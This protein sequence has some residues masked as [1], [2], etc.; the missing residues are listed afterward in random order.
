MS[1]LLKYL[2]C[3]YLGKN[4]SHDDELNTMVYIVQNPQ[5]NYL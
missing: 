4:V 1:I 2:D 3:P 5:L